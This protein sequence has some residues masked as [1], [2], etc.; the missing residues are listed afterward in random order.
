M[1]RSSLSGGREG[2]SSLSTAKRVIAE[3]RTKL[4]TVQADHTAVITKLNE[5]VAGLTQV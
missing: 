4:N 5:S 2:P 1:G 3:L